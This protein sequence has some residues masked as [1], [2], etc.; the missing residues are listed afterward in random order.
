MTVNI[1]TTD[2]TILFAVQIYFLRLGKLKNF[3][4]YS[5]INDSETN[6]KFF[7]RNIFQTIQK[8]YPTNKTDSFHIDIIQSLDILDLKYYGPKNNRNF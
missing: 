3:W 6:E 5:D 1:T 4:L 8:N 2:W 7:R